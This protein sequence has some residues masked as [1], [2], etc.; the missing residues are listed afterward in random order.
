MVSREIEEKI[1]NSLST[2]FTNMF[3]D[4]ADQVETDVVKSWLAN[5]IIKI[6]EYAGRLPQE[7]KKGRDRR[8]ECHKV[9]DGD[10]NQL[11]S[12]LRKTY[13][14]KKSKSPQEL[15]LETYVGIS[16]IHEIL[17]KQK[18]SN[19][20]AEVT[21]EENKVVLNS[22]KVTSDSIDNESIHTTP[23]DST[24]Q[25]GVPEK[26]QRGVKPTVEEDNKNYQSTQNNFKSM[27]ENK[28]PN[29]TEELK[30]KAA[31]AAGK[32]GNT[33]KKSNAT[34]DKAAKDAARAQV[35]EFLSGQMPERH[36]WMETHEV[37]AIVCFKSPAAFRV[38]EE[39]GYFAQ[40]KKDKTAV[41]QAEE[42]LAKFCVAASG[43]VGITPEQFAALPD[44]DKYAQAAE[45]DKTRKE[46]AQGPTNVEKAKATYELLN[47]IL[48]NPTAKIKAVVDP[49][50]VSYSFQG[51]VLSGEP[52]NRMKLAATIIDKT[53]GAYVVAAGSRDIADEKKKSM[54][55]LSKAN[56]K[57]SSKNAT[58]TANQSKAS[59]RISIR[60]TNK[61]QFLQ[62]KSHVVY[63]LNQ[64][65]EKT[66]T[67]PFRA[68]L[69]TL[70]DAPAGFSY[71]DSNAPTEKLKK[72]DNGNVKF[73]KK[74]FGVSVRVEVRD[75]EKTIDSRFVVE[76]LEGVALDNYWGVHTAPTK[77]ES[78][79]NPDSFAGTQL[80]KTLVSFLLGEI[81]SVGVDS[82]IVK[83][84]DAMKNKAAVQ[85]EQ[86]AAMQLDQ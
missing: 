26:D 75:Y 29:V 44:A 2:A 65:S 63:L 22:D 70:G 40:D 28:M 51:V 46:D 47:Q 62:D 83:K 55:T 84:I 12:C 73:P 60:I 15:I 72:D 58:P 43:R 31:A 34:V 37:D 61:A 18:P 78:N 49:E 71:V 56:K 50:E 1:V 85:A 41:Q 17:G 11:V 67:S 82:D 27:E 36:Q 64:Y 9:Y 52:M 23:S 24:K 76:G 6:V 38:T 5:S 10:F 45:A 13:P 14:D 30:A 79:L 66:G 68:A 39:V 19:P 3:P 25:A 80:E 74:T 54:F 33:A 81:D 57:A 7:S 20:T 35:S 86:Q 4:L 21:A 42:R 53:P 59:K 16:D 69:T 8:M 32:M 48:Q 77:Q